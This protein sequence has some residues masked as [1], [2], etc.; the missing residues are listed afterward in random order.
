MARAKP[1]E[2]LLD[3]LVAMSATAPVPLAEMS[4]EDIARRLG[5]TRMTLYRRAG[6]RDDIVA[7]LRARGIDARRQPD[8]HERVIEATARLLREQPI[9]LLTLEHIADAANC[10]LPAIYARFGNRDGVLRAVIERHS[11]LLPMLETI[12]INLESPS[13]DLRRDIRSLYA[14]LFRQVEREWRVIRSFLAELLRDPDSE[15]GQAVR[16]WYV[17]QVRDALV[18]LFQR[19]IDQGT[20]RP[21]PMPI[22]VP[23]FAAP[24]GAHVGIRGYIELETEFPLTDPQTTIDIF[25]DMFCRA[26]G[27]DEPADS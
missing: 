18:P 13:V 24:M 26:V 16:D 14:T 2:E 7:A 15:V 8:V 12:A 3:Q 4:M 11:P 17:P 27:A 10:S 25:T 1:T 9:A 6:T 19:H 5:M 22:V 23:M 20:M 21:L